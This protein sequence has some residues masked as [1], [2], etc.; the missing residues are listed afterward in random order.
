MLSSVTCSLPVAIAPLRVIHIAVHVNSLIVLHR[1]TTTSGYP[2]TRWGIWVFVPWGCFEHLMLALRS[3]LRYTS[4]QWDLGGL[5]QAPIPLYKRMP[6]Y[7][8]KW[9]SHLYPR[10]GSM[11][12]TP[13]LIL[14]GF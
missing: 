1:V 8:P 2:L 4:K 13:L 12:V 9:A 3:L 11:A 5:G 10:C 14:S 7:F 6:N